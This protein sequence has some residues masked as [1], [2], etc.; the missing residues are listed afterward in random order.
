MAAEKRR[1]KETIWLPRSRNVNYIS[2][3]F[4][5]QFKSGNEKLITCNTITSSILLNKQCQNPADNVT[6]CISQVCVLMSQCAPT[7]L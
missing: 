4:T 2:S 6:Q 1:I 5:Q 3:Y 7:A